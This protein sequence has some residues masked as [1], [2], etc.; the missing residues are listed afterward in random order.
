MQNRTY[1][2]M[3]L[4]VL[5]VGSFGLITISYANGLERI[6]WK[7]QHTGL[8]GQLK[9]IER[10]AQN[11]KIMSEGKINFRLY[12]PGSLVPNSEIW[13]AIGNEQ[14]D[15]GM[16][17][18]L[19]ILDKHPDLSFFAA[20]PFAP[21]ITEFTVWMNHGGGQELKDEIY[22][23]KG[24]KALN[25]GLAA[26]ESGGWFKKRYDSVE[27]FKGLN[28]RILGLGSK[29]MEKLGVKTQVVSFKDI[30]SA[31]KKG[32]IDAAEFG[33]PHIDH[34]IGMHKSAKYYYFPGWQQQFTVVEFITQKKKWDGLG[35][36]AQTIIQT[37]CN[38]LYFLGHINSN[39]IQPDAM[40][41]IQKEGVKFVTWKD[42]EI[43]KIEEAWYEV[44]EEMSAEDPLFA[45]VYTKYKSFRE[46]YAI[47][48]DR[49]FLK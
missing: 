40:R 47:W 17:S 32:Q 26:S 1:R 15:A 8:P 4:K 21:S 45:K 18:P 11:I 2:S 43:K 35:K 24:L 28:M 37:S 14:L 34:L 19:Y 49:A 44:A 33:Y 27:E 38:S 42:S 36:A 46:K 23:K 13:N 39:A 6:R 25:C 29:V 30:H 3:L 10:F 16:S 22:A 41:K 9:G 31:F 12:K 7:V 5:L 20:V 48:G